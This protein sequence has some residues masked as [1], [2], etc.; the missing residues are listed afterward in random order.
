MIKTE[1][2]TGNEEKVKTEQPEVT[3]FAA[4]VYKPINPF[5]Y[6]L[7]Q[8]HGGDTVLWLA[9]M[10]EEGPSYTSLPNT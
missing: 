6:N 9:V 8:L 10:G 2:P 4:P 1:T 3:N 5:I 7:I